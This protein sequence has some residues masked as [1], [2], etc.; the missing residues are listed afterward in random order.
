MPSDRLRRAGESKAPAT[1]LELLLKSTLPSVERAERLIRRFCREAG[2]SPQQRDEIGLAVR[3]SVVNAVIHGNRCDARKKV[4]LKAELK[5]FGLVISVQDE[6]EGF[7]PSTL[8]DPLSPEN[9]LREP[10][11]GVFLI[12]SYMDKVTVR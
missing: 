5:K 3:E 8:P 7:D 4:I 11:R 9:L 1:R 6:G 12:N 10:G 2:C